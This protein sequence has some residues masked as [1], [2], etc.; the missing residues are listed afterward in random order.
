MPKCFDCGCDIH[1]DHEPRFASGQVFH[2]TPSHCV[3]ELLA[4]IDVIRKDARRLDWIASNPVKAIMALGAVK[5]GPSLAGA[6]LS[7]GGGGSGGATGL[8][9]SLLG[10]GGGGGG[11]GF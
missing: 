9:G 7:R 5:F 4:E 8:L 1:P 10:G 3:S 6:L 11:G 2:R